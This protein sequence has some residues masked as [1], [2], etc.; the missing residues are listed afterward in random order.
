LTSNVTI[1]VFIAN[2]SPFCT[3]YLT[4]KVVVTVNQQATV[5]SAGADQTNLCGVTSTTLAANTP[6]V[7]TG[8]WS[9]V[10]GAGGTVNNPSSPTSTFDGIAGT[11]YVLK[12]SISNGVCPAS[13]DEVTIQFDEE[14]SAAVAGADI[15]QC[16]N[17]VFTLNAVNPAI[18]TGKWT[19]E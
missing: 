17:S 6:G 15:E 1:K 10:S 11:T 14:P 5:A 19:V 12:W 3:A 4:E 18:G 7:G 16:N 13:E 2:V 9:I 8:A